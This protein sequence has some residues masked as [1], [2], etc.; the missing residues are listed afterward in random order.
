MISKRNLILFL[1]T[2]FTAVIASCNK[3]EDEETSK[4]Y[5]S[6]ELK[7][8]MPYFVSAY[9]H[10]SFELSGLSTSEGGTVGYFWTDPISD[11]RD[12]LRIESD[13]ATKKAIF[14]YTVPDTL[15]TLTLS[16][17]GFAEG[18][19]NTTA[20]ANFTIVKPG[21]DGNGSIT[22]F[23]HY[24]EDGKY[25][26]TRDKSEYI[27]TKIGTQEWMRTNLG[28]TGDGCSYYESESTAQMFGQFYTWSQAQTAC[29]EGW[30]LPSDAEWVEMC[31][32]LG[33]EGKVHEDIHNVAGS[34]MQYIKFNGDPFWEFWPQVKVTDKSRLSFMST[35][36]G[37]VTDK[38]Y[39][40]SGMGT[41]AVYWT[42]DEVNGKGV[43]RY[44]YVEQPNLYCGLYDKD[45]TLATVRCIR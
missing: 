35:G 5:L 39:T 17:S 6:G 19:Y 21:F 13:P 16:A 10:F 15:T 26:D 24:A 2:A 14:E 41:Y 7:L 45:N 30:H 33:F 18:Y 28:W 8:E 31:K 29:P 3:D 25:L 43:A 36:L 40:F 4:S 9:D 44:I 20:Q 37:A 27:T 12:T 1:A 42:A 34:L 38:K 22:G 32:T 11:E 23:I